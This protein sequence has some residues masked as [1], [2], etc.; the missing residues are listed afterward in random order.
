LTVGIFVEVLD[1]VGV[2]DAVHQGNWRTFK[3][4][5]PFIPRKVCPHFGFQLRDYP[6]NKLLESPPP[7]LSTKKSTDAS[8]QI[9]A[10]RQL[11]SDE[12]DAGV[13]RPDRPLKKKE[14]ATK[15]ETP[16]YRKY[17]VT[18]RTP[19]TSPFYKRALTVNQGMCPDGNDTLF[20]SGDVLVVNPDSHPDQIPTLMQ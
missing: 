8:S 16:R 12:H 20:S 11:P 15:K 1:N 7:V 13:D 5:G 19:H 4:N 18:P 2:C 17:R 3:L 10:F 14:T 6:N 9:Y